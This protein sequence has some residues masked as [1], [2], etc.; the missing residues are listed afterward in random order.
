MSLLARI[1]VKDK[2]D[3]CNLLNGSP[4]STLLMLSLSFLLHLYS[5][6]ALLVSCLYLNV[7]VLEESKSNRFPSTST[8]FLRSSAPAVP[9][10]LFFLSIIPAFILCLT[11]ACL[12]KPTAAVKGL[13]KLASLCIEKW[14]EQEKENAVCKLFIYTKWSLYA[15][16]H[17]LGHIQTHRNCY[18]LPLSSFQS[19]FYAFAAN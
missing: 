7:H 5:Q 10:F 1:S 14:G 17:H 18:F 15:K 13:T 16:W 12:Q 9:C 4:V 3:F 2:G 6:T 11:L 8:P 19:K